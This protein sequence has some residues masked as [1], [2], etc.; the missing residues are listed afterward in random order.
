MGLTFND[1]N[2]LN[3]DI[4][5][6]LY[7]HICWLEYIDCNGQCIFYYFETFRILFGYCHDGILRYNLCYIYIPVP[8]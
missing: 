6:I 3:N 8:K 5:S 7:L 2:K 1:T 4:E